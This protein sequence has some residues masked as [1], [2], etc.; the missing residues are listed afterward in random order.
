MNEPINRRKDVGGSVSEKESENGTRTT[1]ATSLSLVKA[2]KDGDPSAYD[3]LIDQKNLQLKNFL[4]KLLRSKE[5]A[6]EVAQDVFICIWQNKE[7]LSET[8]SLD[9]LIFSIARRRAINRIRE[10][11]RF[12]ALLMSEYYRP[13]DYADSPEE[14]AVQ[15]EAQAK[16]DKTVAAMPYMMRRIYV[17]KFQEG[18]SNEEIALE[19]SINQSSVRV[20]LSRAEKR[21]REAVGRG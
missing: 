18:L 7:T 11:T 4:F 8:L 9:G 19:L 14:I 6:E 5:D 10:R 20:Q 21:V 12:N 15:N 17:M 16:I 2:L 3:K 1:H 13:Q